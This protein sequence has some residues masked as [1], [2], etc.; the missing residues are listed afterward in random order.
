MS[1]Y[2]V[3]NPATGEVVETYPTATDEQIADAQQRSADAFASWSQTTV[4]ERAAILTKVADIYG[5]RID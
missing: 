3:L 5:E 4:A 2:Q 1:I